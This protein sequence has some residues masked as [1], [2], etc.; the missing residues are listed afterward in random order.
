MKPRLYFLS[1]EGNSRQVA[2]NRVEWSNVCA[3]HL[4]ELTAALVGG[5]CRQCTSVSVAW[6]AV[7]C[8]AGCISSEPILSSFKLHCVGWLAG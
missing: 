5:I 8:M 4:K 2:T 6:R 3:Q 1:M 7:L